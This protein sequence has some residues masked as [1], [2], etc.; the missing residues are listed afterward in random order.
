MRKIN[1]SAFSEYVPHIN[2][3]PPNLIYSHLINLSSH[4]NTN[5]I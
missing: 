4:L 2:P 1:G 5:H 3:S